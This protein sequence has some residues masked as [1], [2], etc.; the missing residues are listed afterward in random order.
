MKG[1]IGFTPWTFPALLLALACDPDAGVI[2][3]PKHEEGTAL[4]LVSQRFSD[5]SPPVNLGPLVNS[6]AAENA[7]ELSKDGL[8]LYFGSNRPGGQGLQD[9]YVSQRPSLDAPWGAPINL[10]ALNSPFI[11]VGPHLSRDGHLLFF[12]SSRPGGFG[13]V[14]IWVSRRN[15]TH[16]D[17]AWEQ[18]VNLGSPPN[19][20]RF[21]GGASMWGPEF[22]FWRGTPDPAGLVAPTDGDIYLSGIT[23]QTFS[24][25]ALVPELSS[26]A[27]EQRPSIRFDGR[28]IFLSSDRPGSLSLPGA[29]V[30]EDIWVSLRQGNGQMWLTPVNVGPVVN[31]TFRDTQPALSDDGTMLFFLSDRPGGSGNLDIY[32]TTRTVRPVE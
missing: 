19:S 2:D 4:S 13:S 10:G 1:T 24:E 17:F 21:D 20:A 12:N 27:H 29:V 22:Y 16:D 6:A 15:N 7:P 18:P 25:P 3:P 11:D 30:R 31:T 5:W 26:A 28:E 23:G 32:V 8:S 14:D 9:L